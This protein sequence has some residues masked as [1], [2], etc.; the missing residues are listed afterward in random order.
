MFLYELHVGK[1][2]PP[3]KGIGRRL[4]QACV[5]S[6]KAKV[7]HLNVH[8]DQALLPPGENAIGFYERLGFVRTQDV[9]ESA[10]L[11]EHHDAGTI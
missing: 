9:N 6:L 2:E 3:L 8:K 11:M 5:Q 4:V 7:V 10:S 1:C